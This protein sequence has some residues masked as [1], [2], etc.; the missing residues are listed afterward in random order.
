MCELRAFFG[1]ERAVMGSR[2]D[3]VVAGLG[4]II[5]YPGRPTSSRCQR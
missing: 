4:E 1:Y 5:A 3:G 2:G